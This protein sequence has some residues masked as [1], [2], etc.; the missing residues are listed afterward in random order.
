MQS[1]LFI[2]M[3]ADLKTVTVISLSLVCTVPSQFMLH[4]N[5]NIISSKYKSFGKQNTI[6]VLS[7]S[8]QWM[9]LHNII[10][11]LKNVIS[12]IW[13]SIVIIANNILMAS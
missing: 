6:I 2:H 8:Y 12:V 4:N 1:C 11:I 7:H 13:E 10:H 3:H 9:Q 5:N